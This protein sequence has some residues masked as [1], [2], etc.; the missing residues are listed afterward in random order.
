MQLG[1]LRALEFDRIVE[2]VR[3]FALTPMGDERLARLAPSVDPQKVAQ[4]LAATTETA[5]FVTR[6]GGLPLRATGDL[7]EILV[8]LAVEGRA[9]EPLRL[10]A[11]ASFL[12]SVDET[13][14]AIHRVAASFPLPRPRERRR[15]VVQGRNLRGPREDRRV[16]RGRRRREPGA[17]GDPRPAAQAADAPA[18]HARVVSAR[19]GHREVS[20]GAG[21]HRA[22]RPLRARGPGRT[23]EP[24]PRHRARRVHERREPVSRAAQHGRDQQRHRRARGAGERG[25]PAHSAGAHRSL[26]RPRGRSPAD[27][28]R[29]RG[30]RRAA[31]AGALLPVD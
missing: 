30:S 13:R 19:Q 10:L 1:A 21:R 15:G 5:A 2:A 28:R 29:R 23:P 25:S 22:Q 27:D 12:E 7:P 4:L 3:A 14:A 17:Q 24:H 16:G 20:A 31:G 18:R 26:P 9:L 6:H 8:S 11:L